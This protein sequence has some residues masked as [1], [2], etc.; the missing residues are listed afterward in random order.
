M[1][2]RVLREL[3]TCVLQNHAVYF[4]SIDQK[5]EMLRPFP[6]HQKE[7]LILQLRTNLRQGRIGHDPLLPRLH[8]CAGDEP[9]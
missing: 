4:Y 2:V 1:V 8:A 9:G 7:A 6:A 3:G 5:I